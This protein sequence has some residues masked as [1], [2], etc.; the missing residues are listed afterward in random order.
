MKLKVNV[1]QSCPSLC[2]PMDQSPWNSPSQ[3]LEWVAF[4]FSRG[5]SQPKMKLNYSK[6]RNFPLGDYISTYSPRL[7]TI[8]LLLD[9]NQI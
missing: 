6:Q 7:K 4:P 1:A 9:S 5:S 8:P 3:N 2:N